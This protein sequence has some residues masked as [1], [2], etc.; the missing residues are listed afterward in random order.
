[1]QR[2]IYYLLVLL[3]SGFACFL[4]LRRNGFHMA[5][6][7]FMGVAWMLGGAM[8][9]N[10]NALI[11]QTYALLPWLVLVVDRLLDTLRWRALGIAALAI[12]LCTYSSFLP[13]V[14]SGYVLIGIQAAVYALIAARTE[15]HAPW[16]ALVRP[17]AAFAIAVALALGIA[18][19]IL[20]PLTEAQRDS[21]RFH[22]IYTSAGEWAYT[23]DLL[24]SLLSPRLFYDVWQTNPDTTAFIPK[25]AGYWTHYFYI[26]A[27]V[28]LLLLFVRRDERIRVRRLTWFFAVAA[29]LLFL[30][31]MG[32]PPVQWIAYLPIF[33][34]LHFIP[35]FSGAFALALVGLAACGV[36]AL[37]THAV[38]LRRFFA[39]MAISAAV[40]A[41]VPVFIWV[42]GYNHAATAKTTILYSLEIDR[43]VAVLVS[44]LGVAYFRMRREL[45]G[46][47]A[48]VLA[49]ALVI[50][51]LGP[52][53]FERRHARVDIWNDGLPKYVR[54]L[55]QDP[56]LFRIHS[57]D[58]ALHP[59][60]FQGVGIAGISSL[61]VF[62]ES[63]FT[64]L[65]EAFFKTELNPFITTTS[66]LPT[67]RPVLDLLNV[68]YVVTY[69][70]T[71]EKQAALDAGGLK[72]V[73]TDGNVSVFRNPTVWPRAFV[74]HDYHVEPNATE[75][76]KAGAVRLAQDVAVLEARPTF[77]PGGGPA[78]ACQIREYR[79]NRVVISGDDSAPSMLVL[80]D[81][82]G[83]GWTATV[84][85]KMVPILPAYGAFRG[86]E[87][88]AGR[89]EVTMRYR[90][91][92]LRAALVLTLVCLAVAIVAIFFRRDLPGAS[93]VAV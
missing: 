18:A 52:L 21:A 26:G 67:N 33:K 82:F 48:G 79:P 1:M 34:Y 87:V 39:A 53:A 64:A 69:P 20:V 75:A 31:L 22:R 37:V 63:R 50:V 85:G 71:P 77:A 14:I 42:N 80:L 46:S 10:V 91:P 55:Q 61:G 15:K 24:P 92:R 43:V 30:K 74:A 90:V 25:P 57:I 2:D 17:S 35:Y 36:E 70:V 51:E 27:G 11:G 62:N 6:A 78:T 4:L 3:A 8:T 76:M 32:I 38:W 9:Q 16:V 72:L 28:V 66:L 93:Q 84:N 86:V 68:K 40:I 47:T 41:S 23:W 89:W 13:I 44:F 19:I 58:L 49:I 7:V 73:L 83:D 29:A 5:S 12:G 60:T 54:F 65:I 56:E 59:N 45:R 88:P 81:S